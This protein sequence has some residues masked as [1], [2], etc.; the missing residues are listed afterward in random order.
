MYEQSTV[1]HVTFTYFLALIHVLVGNFED[2]I[3]RRSREREK[4]EERGERNKKAR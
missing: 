4:E 2:E 1:E 3:R